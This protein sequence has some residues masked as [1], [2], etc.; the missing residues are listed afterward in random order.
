MAGGGRGS[1]GVS[2]W[3]VPEAVHLGGESRRHRKGLG[4][5]AQRTEAQ[6]VHEPTPWGSIPS[7]TREACCPS[8][9]SVPLRN[10]DIYLPDLQRG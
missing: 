6:Y 4:K 1:W 9:Q 7:Q 3:V 5:W 2:G 8:F 10:W